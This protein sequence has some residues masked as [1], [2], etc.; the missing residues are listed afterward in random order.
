[1]LYQSKTQCPVVIKKL[2]RREKVGTI[3]DSAR[4]IA[5]HP[6]NPKPQPTN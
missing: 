1:V 6:N 2:R 5:G 3:P 4:D